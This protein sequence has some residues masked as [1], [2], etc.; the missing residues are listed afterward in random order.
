MKLAVINGSPKRKNSNTGIFLDHF[1]TG[2][3]NSGE[4]TISLHAVS[5]LEEENEILDLFSAADAVFIAMPLYTNAMHA[6]VKRFFEMLRPISH[7]PDKNPLLMFLVQSGFPEAHHSRYIEKYLKKLCSRLNCE[8]GGTIIRGGMD[9]IN[10]TC[11]A[12]I[13]K[14]IFWL[15]ANRIQKIGHAFGKTGSLDSTMLRQFAF[16]ERMPKIAIYLFNIYSFFGIRYLGFDKELMKNN[17]FEQRDA[18][19]YLQEGI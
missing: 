11:P 17:M 13:R 7:S 14:G 12:L 8:Y 4:K 9:T 19:P 15:L 3:K 1:I 16:P 6:D 18:T 10:Q 5:D 2:F